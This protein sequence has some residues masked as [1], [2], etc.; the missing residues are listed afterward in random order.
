M[1]ERRGARWVVEGIGVI[2][3]IG[4]LI[5]VG[6]GIRQNSIATKAATDAAVADSFREL[7]LAQATSS[8]LASAFA[9]HST[10]PRSAPAEAQVLML[11][12]WRALLHIWPTSTGSMGMEQS[13]PPST[14]RSPARFQAMQDLRRRVI[15]PVRSSFGKGSCRG[16]GRANGSFQQ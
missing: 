11:G 8:E 12:F 1:V 16:R 7:S 2:G 14:T 15:P 13:T 6:I 4:S 3:V 9:A 10:N 5:F